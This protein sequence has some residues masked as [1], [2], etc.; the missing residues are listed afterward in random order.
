MHATILIPLP[1][2]I[3]MS[4][5]GMY[6]WKSQDLFI[7]TIYPSQNTK[8]I[9]KSGAKL[10]PI[11]LKGSVGKCFEFKVIMCLLMKHHRYLIQK[12]VNSTP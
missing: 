7:L 8:F 6:L 5:S 3:D 9:E 2:P 4:K 10:H 11:H 1:I 12:P